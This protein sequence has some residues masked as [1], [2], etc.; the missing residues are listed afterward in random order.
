LSD[1]DFSG[2]YALMGLMLVS[3]RFLPDYVISMI[4]FIIIHSMPGN[5][6]QEIT[7]RLGKLQ[8]LASG[9][10]EQMRHWHR[11]A[12]DFSTSMPMQCL[13]R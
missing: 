8:R 4:I 11:L 12:D 5:N 1:A 2:C 6:R 9:H 7:L 13:A 10:L 3:L